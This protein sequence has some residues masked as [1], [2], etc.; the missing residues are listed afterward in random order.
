M[1]SFLH[2]RA[3]RASPSFHSDV[4]RIRSPLLSNSAAAHGSHRRRIHRV[5]RSR[6]T[7]R[8]P[9]RTAVLFI[10]GSSS[11]TS[12]V[13]LGKP[14]PDNEGRVRMPLASIFE[15]MPQRGII[16]EA[17]IAAVGAGGSAASEPSNPFSFEVTSTPPAPPAPPP[18]TL[19]TPPSPGE[20]PTPWSPC[21][22]DVSPASRTVGVGGGTL[23][24]SVGAL[25]GLRVEL[26]H[27]RGMDRITR[28]RC[29][30][31]QWQGDVRRR[32]KYKLHFAKRVGHHRRSD[33]VRQSDGSGCSFTVSPTS[34]TVERTGAMVSIS[35]AAPGGCPW[36]ASAQSPWISITD[37]ASGSGDGTVTFAIE[38]NGAPGSALA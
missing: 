30:N 24:F 4:E 32:E 7:T 25:D 22:Y 23:S 14:S 8:L 18:P 15:T 20:P 16:Y 2:M 11:P 5:V 35:V 28:R 33:S 12:V 36:S 3:D 17:R 19:P 31:R 26:V 9:L 13:S 6:L 34:R 37:G 29:G 21:S 10:A 38:A 1:A 27:R